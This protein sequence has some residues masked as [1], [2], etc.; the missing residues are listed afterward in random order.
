MTTPG[1][2]SQSTGYDA[3]HR[4]GENPWRCALIGAESLLVEC[5]KLLRARGHVVVAVASDAAGPRDWANACGVPLVQTA[6][7]LEQAGPFEDGLALC[8]ALPASAA[9]RGADPRGR[10]PGRPSGRG[11]G[12]GR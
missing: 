5:G 4:L 2:D 8:P 10:P 9:M 3:L 7:D 1:F 12:G 6:R 11:C